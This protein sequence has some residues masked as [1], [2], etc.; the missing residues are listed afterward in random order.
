M[1]TTERYYH[2]TLEEY[3]DAFLDAGLRLAKLADVPHG[4]VI[5]SFLV[6]AFDKPQRPDT[7]HGR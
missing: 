5:P 6:L 1:G 2:R 3:V 7:P 4:R